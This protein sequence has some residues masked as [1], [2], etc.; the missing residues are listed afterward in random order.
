MCFRKHLHPSGPS[1]LCFSLCSRPCKL[2]NEPFLN[3]KFSVMHLIFW[4]NLLNVICYMFPT[5]MHNFVHNLTV[6]FALLL[7][8][9]ITE[10]IPYIVFSSH[11]K[12]VG[13]MGLYCIHL[14]LVP[15]TPIT[16][17]RDEVIL[18]A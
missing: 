15:I 18:Y 13:N 7:M 11:W 3:F 8:E 10:H 4:K 1:I 2:Y 17:H 9:Q 14:L 12:N 6:L 16:H 5:K